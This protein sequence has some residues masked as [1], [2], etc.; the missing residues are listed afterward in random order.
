VAAEVAKIA[1]L[2]ANDDNITFEEENNISKT[3]ISFILDNETLI[4]DIVLPDQIEFDI[5]LISQN[6]ILNIS[7]II[8]LQELHNAFSRS[9]KLI[10]NSITVNY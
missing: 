3:E 1:Q 7:N 8:K 4:E 2:V 6:N 5:E 9:E 10:R